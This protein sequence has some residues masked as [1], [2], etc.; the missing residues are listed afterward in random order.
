MKMTSA[1]A[2]KLLRKLDEQHKA[3]R[4][5]EEQSRTFVAALD[6][7]IESI[8]PAYDY[9]EM[10]NELAEIEMK[11]RKIKH[12]I[13]MFNT[14]TVIPEFGIT[15]DEMLV[16]LPQLNH[17]ES[18][19]ARMK[20]ELP[21]TREGGGYRSG[22]AVIDYRLANYDIKQAEADYNAVSDELAKAQTALDV[23]NNTIELDIEL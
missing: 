19:L 21:K 14:T 13:N 8:R 20:A 1:Q 4:H 17:R 12:A 5:R 15:I 9:S 6:E 3:L 10:Q 2:A 22:S 16:Y 7:D 23:V 11:I 18:K